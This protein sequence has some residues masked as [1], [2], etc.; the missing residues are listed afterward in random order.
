MTLAALT[1]R[2]PFGLLF[3][4][5]PLELLVELLPFELL[6]EAISTS[7]GVREPLEQLVLTLLE[8]ALADP[9]GLELHLELCELAPD[10]RLVI[11]LA[12]RLERHLLTDPRD[13]AH[14]S[15]R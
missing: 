13:P 8:L 2:L 1:R 14:G 7:P 3:E 11:Q 6:F 15:Q 5:L 4:R 12:L 9:A 10:P